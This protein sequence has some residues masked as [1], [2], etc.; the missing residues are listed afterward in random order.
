M[1]NRKHR[2]NSHRPPPRKLHPSSYGVTK[3]RPRPIEE[4]MTWA[5]RVRDEVTKSRDVQDVKAVGRC[6]TKICNSPGRVA[7]SMGSQIGVA[8]WAGVF[9]VRGSANQSELEDSGRI[10]T[11]HRHSHHAEHRDRH[12][13]HQ[14]TR[15]ET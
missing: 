13:Q 15:R 1:M 11:Y 14:K 8:L 10:W 4:K 5:D 6:R 7:T 12:Q 9:E 2:K 3:S